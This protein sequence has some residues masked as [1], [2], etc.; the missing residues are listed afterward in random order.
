MRCIIKDSMALFTRRDFGALALLAG[1][2]TRRL[3]AAGGLDETLRQEVRRRAIP[4]AAA[5]V[6][7]A[8]NTLYEGAVGK[9]DSASG[10][11]ATVDSLFRIASMT[12]PVTAVAAMQLVE[13]GK[14][15]LNQ[16]V[17]RH[18]PKLG[19]LQVL[20]GFDPATGKPVLRPARKPV[21]LRHLLTHTSGFVYDNWD[22]NL[23][24]YLEHAAPVD[25]DTGTPVHPLMF[26][27]GTRWEYGTS[28]DWAGRLVEA[29]SGLT[30]EEYFQ[31]NILRPLGMKDTSFIVP[32]DKF[33]R[34]V[35]VWQR[36][37]DGSLK[38]QPRTLPAPPKSYNGGGGLNSTPRDYVRFM[39]MILRRGSAGD[40]QQVL[41]PRTVDLMASNRI[42]GLSAGKLKSVKPENSSDVDFHPGFSDGFG[43]GFLINAKAYQGGRSARSLAWAGIRNTF[44]WIDPRRGICATLM[45][46]FYPFCDREAMGLLH[47]FEQSVYA[48]AAI[49]P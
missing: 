25:P 31:R 48:T 39:Q 21:L 29:V 41:R 35:S 24:R 47:D 34:L 11:D 30:L 28:M 5:M 40:G 1:T 26:E 32:E 16:P 15:A 6:A 27:P 42:G 4:L 20:E 8:S 43:F 38:E 3:S 7:T 23:V 44:F 14:L 17:A 13:Q 10:I 45:M 46:Q 12:K 33:D 49:R 22:A 18:L 2:P 36:Q 19:G 37:A 9:R